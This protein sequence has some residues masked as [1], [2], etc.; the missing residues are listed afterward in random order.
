MTTA[1]V[2]P[3]RGLKMKNMTKMALISLSL[4]GL[5]TAAPAAYAQDAT[6]AAAPAPDWTLV[7]YVAGQSDYRFRGITQSD[8]N[9]VPQR[10]AYSQ[11]P[12]RFLCL[13]LEVSQINWQLNGINAETP[14]IEWDI[15]G[16]KHFRPGRHRPECRGL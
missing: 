14:G 5:F 8:R 7:G 9:P 12:G 1:L 15:Y 10:L 11:R 6:P 16:G 4:M 3:T 2:R 13:Y